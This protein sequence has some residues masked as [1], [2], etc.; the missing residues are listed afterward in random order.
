MK[1]K[2][3]EKIFLNYIDYDAVSDKR[4]SKTDREYHLAPVWRDAVK[5]PPSISRKETADEIRS[6]LQSVV[7]DSTYWIRPSLF[8]R[9]AILADRVYPLPPERNG[10]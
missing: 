1:P 3:R 5:E 2:P 6:I 10:E 9:L 7:V 4:E 8:D